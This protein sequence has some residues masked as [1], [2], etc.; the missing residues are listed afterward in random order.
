MSRGNCQHGVY[1][2][3]ETCV[4]CEAAEATEAANARI[5]ALEERIHKLEEQVRRI[6]PKPRK[7]TK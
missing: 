5:D 4:Q 2:P 1:R 7:G 6:T 3:F